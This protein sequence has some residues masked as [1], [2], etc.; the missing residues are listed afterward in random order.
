MNKATVSRNS[1]KII[2]KTFFLF[3]CFSL[4]IIISEAQIL[5]KV[6]T[7]N[8][9]YAK[10]TYIPT[11][12]SSDYGTKALQLQASLE[13]CVKYFHSTLHIN[14]DS[15]YLTVFDDSDFKEL[16]ISKPYG[17]P[18]VDGIPPVV[19]LPA[20]SSGIVAMQTKSLL[21]HLNEKNILEETGY[22]FTGAIDK[23]VD[24]I[25]FHELGHLYSNKMG[26]Q[27]KLYNIFWLKEFVANYFAYSYLYR[28]EPLSDHLWTMMSDAIVKSWSPE[29]QRLEEMEKS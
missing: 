6:K 8:V 21:V 11:Y 24:M 3:L 9:S 23:S 1:I 10:G 29:N 19:F 16:N 28:N 12:Y 14:I 15:L 20:N 26:I 27:Q 4:F 2:M 17:L 18:F 22:D 5:D 25:G 7:L 13:K